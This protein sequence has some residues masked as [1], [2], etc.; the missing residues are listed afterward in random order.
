VVNKES[1]D[2]LRNIQRQLRD[3][4]RGVANQTNRSLNESLQATLMAAQMEDN[5][6]NARVQEL[7]RQVNILNQ[8]VDNAIKLVPASAG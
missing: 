1:R 2:R 7:S 5:E 3:H 8:V 6:R 4:Y